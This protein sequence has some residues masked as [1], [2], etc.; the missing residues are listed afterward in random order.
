MNR[1]GVVVMQQKKK[2]RNLLT[3]EHF[4]FFLLL[5]AILVNIKSIFTECDID[6][7]YAVAMSY[8]MLQGDQM[9]KQMWEPHQT[10]AFL[11]TILMKPFLAVAGTTGIVLYL[12]IM[13]VL[14]H[15]AIVYIFYLFMKKRVN[16]QTARLMSILFLAVRPKDIVLPEFSNMQIWFSV[17]LFLS[18][19]YYLEHQNKKKWLILSSVFLCLEVISYPSCIIVWFAVAVL[20]W[21]YSATKW[22]DILLFTVACSIQGCAYIGYFVIRM[23]GIMPLVETLYAIVSSDVSHQKDGGFLLSFLGTKILFSF[24]WLALG[25]LVAVVICKLLELRKKVEQKREMVILLIWIVLMVSLLIRGVLWSNHESHVVLY[26]FIMIWALGL[27]KHCDEQERRIVYAGIV[28]SVT[29]VVATALL[30]NLD[31]SSTLMYLVLGIVVSLIPLG[32]LKPMGL[33]VGRRTL[34]FEVV[35]LICM[36]VLF[37]RSIVVKT[38]GGFTNPLKI[39]GIVRSGPSVGILTDYMGA[40]VRN[41][42]FEEW[43]EFIQE[44]DN[45]LLVERDAMSVIGYLYGDTYVSAPSTICTPT[46]DETLLEYWEKYPE[47]YPDVVVVYCWYGNLLVEE[48]SWIIQ[49]LQNDCDLVSVDDGTFWRYYRLADR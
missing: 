5:I 19:L 9:L 26:P 16:L 7:E 6:S 44:G 41:T 4:L 35:F 45:I 23:G 25:I 8:R 30:T 28:I 2:G 38:S 46:F 18:L 29:S 37:Q 22:K 20:L 42:T 31:L 39:G 49:W 36:I 13:G 14:I 33:I 1:E 12:Q 32:K 27:A 11:C 17:L 48:E 47:K 43:D 40:L 24:L 3:R 21:I 15:G 10:S 34:R